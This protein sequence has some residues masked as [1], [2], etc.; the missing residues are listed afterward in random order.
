MK[1]PHLCF[2][3]VFLVLFCVE[4]L[5]ALFVQD[6]WIRPYFGDILVMI[7]LY[8]LLRTIMP[9]RIWKKLHKRCCSLW[10]PL[11]FVFAVLVE[12]LQGIHIV[13]RLGLSGN[14]AAR[15]VI[16]TS[17]DWAD[18]LCYFSGCV[19]LCLVEWMECRFFKK[20][21]SSLE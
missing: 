19:V 15:T 4:V 2:G 7:V 9:I 21:L 5:I 16:G 8:S 6:N 12:L 10:I 14:A 20:S 1:H 3:I 18:L 11:L 17:F 13:E